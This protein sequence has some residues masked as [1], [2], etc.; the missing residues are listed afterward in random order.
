MV[1]WDP[2]SCHYDPQ[3]DTT[4]NITF[5]QLRWRAV[6]INSIGKFIQIIKRVGSI[7][8]IVEIL[9]KFCGEIIWQCSNV[10]I[11]RRN[12]MVNLIT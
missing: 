12:V 7:I 2:P 6:I 1:T 10:T 3:T 8:G 4:E 11:A 5:L 9:V